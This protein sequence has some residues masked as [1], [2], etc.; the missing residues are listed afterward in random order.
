MSESLDRLDHV[1]AL[2]GLD[3]GASPTA[4]KSATCAH[5]GG[6]P[7]LAALR[8]LLLLL[9]LLLALLLEPL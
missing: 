4:E 5:K 9:A 1:L 6:R 8:L 2:L 3:G 7:R